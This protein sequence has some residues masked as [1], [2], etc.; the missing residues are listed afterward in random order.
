MRVSAAPFAGTDI[1]FELPPGK[2]AVPPTADIQTI[3]Y[4][5]RVVPILLKKS[6]IEGL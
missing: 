1:P 6:K 2:S 3:A 5:V 4:D